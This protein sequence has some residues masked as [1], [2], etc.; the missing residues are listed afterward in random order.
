[1]ASLRRKPDVVA[2]A[3]PETPT[4][5]NAEP[6]VSPAT[7]APE[8]ELDAAAEALKRQ[9][10]ALRELKICNSNSKSRCRPRTSAAKLGLN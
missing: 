3:A 10:D 4:M 6:E 9:I 5:E 7:P 2:E 1:M 8:P